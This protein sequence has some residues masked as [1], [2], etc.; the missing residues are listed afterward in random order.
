LLR[1]N[2]GSCGGPLKR[3]IGGCGPI[4]GGGELGPDR[5]PAVAADDDN[6]PASS[7]KMRT[8]GRMI[9]PE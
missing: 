1:E 6:I 9:V 5:S 3:Q 4:T 7:A 8:K 2:G